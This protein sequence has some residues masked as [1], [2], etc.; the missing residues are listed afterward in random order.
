VKV[1]DLVAY[2]EET[3]EPEEPSR[4]IIID[5]PWDTMNNTVRRYEIVWYTCGNKGW[6]EEKNLEVLSESR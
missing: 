6:W 1:G 3:I 5:G 2:V 4:G